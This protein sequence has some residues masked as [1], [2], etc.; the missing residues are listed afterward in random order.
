[1]E[2]DA[3]LLVMM[4]Q[5]LTADDVTDLKRTAIKVGVIWGLIEW[6]TRK[7]F[8]SLEAV[9]ATI[10]VGFDGIKEGFRAIEVSFSAIET[11]FRDIKVVMKNLVSSVEKIEKSNLGA[12]ND[13]S[14][15]KNRLTIIEQK[16]RI[17]S[18]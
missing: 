12:E 1:M 9:V 15:L 14:D 6:R 7:R 4:G 2:F 18:L 8:N 10:R 17:T 11:S 13:L 3:N 5:F 16:A